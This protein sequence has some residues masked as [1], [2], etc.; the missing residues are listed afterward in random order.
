MGHDSHTAVVIHTFGALRAQFSLAQT[1]K[2]SHKHSYF[3]QLWVEKALGD[4]TASVSD[5]FNM[6]GGVAWTSKG[7]LDFS[8][9]QNRLL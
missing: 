9:H 8:L 6:C 5:S 3:V 2:N 1:T 7:S 4:V